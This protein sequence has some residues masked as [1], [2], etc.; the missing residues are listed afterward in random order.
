M[1]NVNDERPTKAPLWISPL[2]QKENNIDSGSYRAVKRQV[3]KTPNPS[4]AD[5]SH[6]EV[7]TCLE[8]YLGPTGEVLWRRVAVR[9]CT[10]AERVLHASFVLPEDDYGSNFTGDSDVDDN[11]HIMCWASFPERPGHQILCVL[12]SPLLLCIWDAYPLSGENASE[13]IGG[14]EG[15]T[16]SLPFEARGIFPLPDSKGLLLQRKQ[17]LEDRVLH[18]GTRLSWVGREDL[19]DDFDVGDFVLQD[20]PTPV[21]LGTILTSPSVMEMA[22]TQPSPQA[23]AATNMA[24]IPSL[25]SLKHPL[26]EILP[27]TMFQCDGSPAA[28]PDILEQILFV[29]ALRWAEDDD[30]PYS[31]TEFTQPICVTY[32]DQLKR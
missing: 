27:V 8:E 2:Y 4:F 19:D 18:D 7:E 16:L 23:S 32:H 21:R 28:F 5:T 11:N 1:A 24:P 15:N 29:G 25:F 31:K 6:G 10:G 14:G 13:S 26:D 30:N 3:T 20:P 12:A 17:T 9:G 22:I